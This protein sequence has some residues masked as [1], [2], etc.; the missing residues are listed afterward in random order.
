M[1][2]Q[3][4]KCIS[5]YLNFDWL[6]GRQRV[7]QDQHQVIHVPPV[8]TG[9]TYLSKEPQQVIDLT[10][11]TTEVEYKC[12]IDLINDTT[13]VELKC[14]DL[15]CFLDYSWLQCKTSQ[16][17]MVKETSKSLVEETSKTL[18][19]E[20]SKSL[21]EKTSKTLLQETSKTVVEEISDI[22]SI[23][24]IYEQGHSSHSFSNSNEKEYKNANIL[25]DQICYSACG[26]TVLSR[27]NI[28]DNTNNHTGLDIPYHMQK[29][30]E[31]SMAVFEGECDVQEELVDIGDLVYQHG[32][33][34]NTT[35]SSERKDKV[36]MWEK[37][38]STLPVLP[39]ICTDVCVNIESQDNNS[40]IDSNVIE[41]APGN[42]YFEN[43][44]SE[45]ENSHCIV[46]NEQTHFDRIQTTSEEKLDSSSSSLQIPESDLD[47]TIDLSEDGDQYTMGKNIGCGQTTPILNESSWQ[48]KLTFN[49]EKNIPVGDTLKQTQSDKIV[50]FGDKFGQ[51]LTKSLTMSSDFSSHLMNQK[52]RWQIILDRLETSSH[53]SHFSKQNVSVHDPKKPK[54]HCECYF[55]DLEEND[56]RDRICN[57]KFPRNDINK[58]NIDECYNN[59]FDEKDGDNVGSL[60]RNAERED[61]EDAECYIQNIGDGRNTECCI[62]N[63]GD[64][65]GRNTKCCIQNIGDGSSVDYT[66]NIKNECCNT[67]VSTENSNIDILTKEHCPKDIDKENAHINNTDRQTNKSILCN[68]C[69]GFVA[70]TITKMLAHENTTFHI[71]GKFGESGLKSKKYECN[72]CSSRFVKSHTLR[73]HYRKQHAKYRAEGDTKNCIQCNKYRRLT[74]EGCLNHESSAIFNALKTHFNSHVVRTCS[75]KQSDD[76]SCEICN[77]PFSSKQDLDDHMTTHFENNSNKCL[78][79]DRDFSDRQSLIDHIPIHYDTQM[80]QNEDENDFISNCKKTDVRLQSEEPI[81]E[82]GSDCMEIKILNLP[83][84]QNWKNIHWK[85]DRKGHSKITKAVCKTCPN[86]TAFSIHMVRLHEQ[87]TYHIRYKFGEIGLRLLKHEC[88]VCSARFK[89]KDQKRNHFKSKHLQQLTERAIIVSVNEDGGCDNKTEEPDGTCD[90]EN[91]TNQSENGTERQDNMNNNINERKIHNKKT[92]YEKDINTMYHEY[93]AGNRSKRSRNGTYMYNQQQQIITNTQEQLNECDLCCQSFSSEKCLDDHIITHFQ[94]TTFQC[95]LC[96]MEFENRKTLINHIAIH[97]TPKVR[98]L[99][100]IQC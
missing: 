95:E 39:T 77:Q 76:H 11:D 9:S 60:D 25:P 4:E 23:D 28:T 47:N 12:E 63:I 37:K 89:Y 79:C 27:C 24:A 19:E 46:I 96:K 83:V 73:Y 100:K 3:E 1:R 54:Q 10:N 48:N 29:I 32:S 22:G 84:S 67:T 36:G 72:V 15:S 94:S 21:V 90:Y 59:N 99:N 44:R 87:M 91:K 16:R 69:P 14:D 92:R 38:C 70:S 86:F 98:R 53:N 26:N 52:G 20:T 82:R 88:C 30:N 18:V 34:N 74:N 75:S 13:D 62:Q 31:S 50:K 43:Q 7:D 85:K 61:F 33:Y 41:L 40:E 17:K 78:L 65:D 57:K 80:N 2:D 93:E 55:V 51:I 49:Q 58:D 66:C 68:S 64:G 42:V 8:M 6:S 56:T 35:I 45:T 71:R 81:S 5:S 97:S